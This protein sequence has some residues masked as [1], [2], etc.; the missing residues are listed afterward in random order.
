MA[1]KRS[2]T[3]KPQ[4]PASTSGTK[5]TD[6]RTIADELTDRLRDLIIKGVLDAGDDLTE[7]KLRE[8][9][10]QDGYDR[11][12][13]PYPLRQALVKL[14]KEGFVEIKPQAWTRV[15]YYNRSELGAI[16]DSRAVLEEFI[17]CQLARKPKVTLGPAV[18]LNQEMKAIAEKYDRRQT[19][20]TYM[21][22]TPEDQHRFV[23]LDVQ[24]HDSLAKAAG[25]ELL[26]E[27]LQTLRLRLH[28]K[29]FPELYSDVTR[30]RAVVTEHFEIL[31]SISPGVTGVEPSR[32]A[33]F[34][35]INDV[36]LAIRNHLRNSAKRWKIE[37]ELK[38]RNA[39]NKRDFIFDLP[40]VYDPKQT[41]AVSETHIYTMRIALELAAVVELCQQKARDL[42]SVEQFNREM[43]ILS[44]NCTGRRP[45]K[46]EATAFINLDIGF[47]SALALLSGLIF[48]QAGIQHTWSR[49]S[50]ELRQQLIENDWHMG[51]V[52]EEHAEVI[53]QLRNCMKSGNPDDA[54]E[55][56]RKHLV[57]ALARK[58]GKT[59]AGANSE[60]N[61]T[62]DA[63]Q[64]LTTLT[65]KMAK[66]VAN[67][68]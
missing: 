26:A 28:Q 37:S 63:S 38:Y 18:D 19:S 48:A 59:K 8:C 67:K 41:K 31:E 66:W 4:K 55:A 10:A 29:V 7:E 17:A 6:G 54:V 5:T 57:A 11:K 44:A 13:S 24:F 14:E 65:N 40:D 36:Q 12:F 32:T 34:P 68:E 16:W 51:K 42:S 25:Y 52:V 30:M 46:E 21:P 9:L 27:Q 39:E 23:E 45:T 58:Q 53:T 60:K 2:S 47:H 43:E 1:R 61:S 3:S 50:R 33:T 62:T 35:V 22:P 20:A 15:R 49:L 64:K 56:M